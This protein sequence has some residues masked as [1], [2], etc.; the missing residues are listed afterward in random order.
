MGGD[1]LLIAKSDLSALLRLVVGL[2]PEVLLYWM[3]S[4]TS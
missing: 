3:S 1:P 2:M 4:A